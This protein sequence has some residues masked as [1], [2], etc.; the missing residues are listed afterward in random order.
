MKTN[1]FLSVLIV[2]LISLN[3]TFAQTTRDTVNVS[4]QWIPGG[5]AITFIPIT[6]ISLDTPPI[7]LPIFVSP[8]G[9]T[10]TGKGVALGEWF[11]P[12]EAGIGEHVITYTYLAKAQNIT[13]K[14]YES[15]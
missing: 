10:F 9:G 12:K 13:I 2:F 1:I 6:D 15:E 7:Y 14:V 8:I 5:S 4:Y 3:S 11:D